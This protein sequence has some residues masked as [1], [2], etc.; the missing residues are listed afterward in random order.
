M[1][2]EMGEGSRYLIAQS[3]TRAVEGR[4]YERKPDDPLYR[5]LR[6][7]ALDPAA[8][9]LEGSVT[10]VNVPFEPLG[11]AFRGA[12][13]E[14]D[15][16][17]GGNGQQ[18]QYLDLD[19][20][21]VLLEDGRTPS[22]FDPLFHQQMVY[23]V[24]SLVYAAFKAALGRDIAWGF[25]AND[26]AQRLRLRPYAMVEDNA[27]YD[28]SA[29][30]LAF[31]YY[32]AAGT[33]YGRNLPKGVVFTSL[34]HD[35]VA[36]ETTHALLDGLRA[37]FMLPTGPDVLGFHEG[38]A[39]IVAIFQR[40]S[41]EQVVRAALGQAR[42][43]LGQ[44]TTL[45]T[46]AAQFG[47]T[48]GELQGLRTATDEPGKPKRYSDK[49]EE[50]DLGSVLV[51]AVF[52]A[53]LTVYRRKTLRYLRLAS[54]GTGMLPPGDLPVELQSILAE[55]ACKLAAQFQAICIRAIDYCPPVDIEL[56]EYLR[57][58]IT[59][60]RELVPDDRWSF[61]E[62]LID[63]F[64]S[65]TIYPPGVNFLSEDA[66]LWCAPAKTVARIEPL[67]FAELKFEGD[68]CR[69]AS[70][71][72]LRRQ[73]GALGRVVTAPENLDVFGLAAEGDS[74]LKGDK[75]SRPCVHSIRSS[76]RIGPNGQV[77]FDLVAEVTQTRIVGQKRKPGFEFIGGATVVIGPDGAIRY[78]IS[79]SVLNEE[80][81]KRQRKYIAS[82]RGRELWE[83]KDAWAPSKRPFRRLHERRKAS[84]R[85]TR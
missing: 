28:E 65:R 52:D 75:L 12:L 30:E 84:A 18:Y 22:P 77:V 76:R 5:P 80:R 54:G 83:E 38:F 45:T 73:A 49:L 4:P 70:A 2:P 39:D 68:P 25:T 57:A 69:P 33:V 56:G 78:V 3:V 10:T 16:C 1:K 63:G 44:A 66:L 35:I 81:L 34:S 20:R 46:L 32:A 40:F 43:D 6:I 37:H 17:D 61:R 79:K 11:K 74:R 50:H 13:F 29:G 72:E 7:F 26:G 23:A 85:S 19:D 24:A 58:L 41:Y 67:A 53:F 42:G 82:D 21:K 71:N 36:H 64:R 48:L 55:Q 27:Y 60:D 31:G 8:S 14:V 59:A 47:Q 15:P 62:A 9:Q 51:S